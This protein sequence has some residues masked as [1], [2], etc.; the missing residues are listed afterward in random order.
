MEINN[1]RFTTISDLALINLF[2]K[3]VG[4]LE[5]AFNDYQKFFTYDGLKV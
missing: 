3:R 5:Q 2:Y 4:S 1:L